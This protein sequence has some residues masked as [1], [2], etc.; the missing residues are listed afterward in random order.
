ML[1]H[2]SSLNQ[3]SNFSQLKEEYMHMMNNMSP[4]DSN[5]NDSDASR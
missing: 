4:T 1:Y 2:E 5:A 3:I